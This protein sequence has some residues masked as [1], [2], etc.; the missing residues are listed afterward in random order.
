MQKYDLAE[1]ALEF[2]SQAERFEKSSKIPQAIDNYNKAAEYMKQ[3]GLLEHR[4]NEIHTKINNLKKKVNLETMYQ[5]VES[6]DEIDQLQLQAFNSI[7]RAKKLEARHDWEDA[8]QH[9]N[10]AIKMLKGAGWGKERLKNLELKLQQ[11]IQRPNRQYLKLEKKSELSQNE[12]KSESE[13]LKQVEGFLGGKA[14]EEKIKSESISTFKLK[15]KREEKIQ[16]QAFQFL[17]EAKKQ[18]EAEDYLKAIINYQK[19]VDLLNSIGWSQQTQKIRHLIITLKRRI[20]EEKEKAITT[21]ER[22]QK[23]TIPIE[24]PEIESESV[25]ELKGFDIK[26]FEVKKRK[27][28]EIQEEA[29]KLIDLANSLERKGGYDAAIQ[30]LKDA[31]KLLKSIGWSDYT[32][33]VFEQINQIREKKAFETYK[34]ELEKEK[35]EYFK[36]DEIVNTLISDDFAEKTVEELDNLT[37][38]ISLMIKNKK[39]QVTKREKQKRESIKVQATE[40]SKSMG[41]LINLK[42]EF[43]EELKK[44]KEAEMKK[45]KDKKK[46][47]IRENLDDIAKMLDEVAKKKNDN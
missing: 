14:I 10:S 22:V 7:Q 32:R 12:I 46:Q 20:K 29:F 6:Q 9:Y 45:E 44:A 15:K 17:D 5:Q 41:D 42:K 35:K 31:I 40:F 36:I 47:K 37:D 25:E 24:S 16:D 18:E 26:E 19:A 30:N 27:I 13:R 28:E 2:L 21:Q 34:K 38:D 3:S 11:L 1:K 43:A 39:E 33:P 8:I 4:I 23:E